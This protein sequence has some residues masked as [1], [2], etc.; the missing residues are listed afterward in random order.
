[1]RRYDKSPIHAHLCIFSSS[2]SSASSAVNAL[3]FI[4]SSYMDKIA[5]NTD[6]RVLVL[7]PGDNVAIAKSDIP[8]GTTVQVMAVTGTLKAAVEGGHKFAFRK[9]AKGE[10]ITKN[11]A[12]TGGGTPDNV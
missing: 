8:A 5:I 11:G 1:M 9:G 3:V 10:S 2:A 12:P 6:P 4:E 7:A